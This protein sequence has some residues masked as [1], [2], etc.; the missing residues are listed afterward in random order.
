ML[1]QEAKCFAESCGMLSS[2]LVPIAQGELCVISESYLPDYLTFW[3]I[4]CRMSRLACPVNRRVFPE[5]LG[6]DREGCVPGVCF[7]DL[8]SRGARNR[9]PTVPSGIPPPF[10]PAAPCTACSAA[11]SAAPVFLGRLK[12]LL[13]VRRSAGNASDRVSVYTGGFQQLKA[14]AEPKLC[15]PPPSPHSL[16]S[17]GAGDKGGMTGTLASAGYRPACR[18]SQPHLHTTLQ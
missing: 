11:A 14:F 10:L 3:K 8:I 7:R 5:E 18:I 1:K 4:R 2:L 15:S 12:V 6:T 16:Q 13:R 17:E 9:Q